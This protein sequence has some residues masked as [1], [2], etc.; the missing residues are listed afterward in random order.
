MHKCIK[1]TVSR[2]FSKQ[3]STYV[4]YV[5]GMMLS[6][7]ACNKNTA[8]YSFRTMH[9]DS[10]IELSEIFIT[11]CTEA[12]LQ[13]NHQHFS[14]FSIQYTWRLSHMSHFSENASS[15]AL[16]DSQGPRGRRL[17]HSFLAQPWRQAGKGTVNGFW[18]TVE[19]PACHVSHNPLQLR[20]S[21]PTF[22]LAGASQLE[23]M[24]PVPLTVRM[25]LG[26]NC[27]TV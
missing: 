7:Q 9:A 10:E 4:V 17:F 3:F 19:I 15:S 14:A 20:Q 11:G 18:K 23:A 2:F 24:S 22:R 16:P 27:V 8:F 5:R 21:Q 1:F 6:I 26:W 12:K 25:P 13:K